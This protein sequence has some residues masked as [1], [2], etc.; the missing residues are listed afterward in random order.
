MAIREEVQLSF[1]RPLIALE[2]S[3]PA[4]ATPSSEYGQ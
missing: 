2:L 3:A 1:R 4:E